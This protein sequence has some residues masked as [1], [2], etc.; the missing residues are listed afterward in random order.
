MQHPKRRVLTDSQPPNKAE[1]IAKTIGER[2]RQLL[3]TTGLLTIR[4]PSM[5]PR[6]Y[7]TLRWGLKP[8]ADFPDDVV[9]YIDGSMLNPRRRELAT[10]GF[11]IAAVGKDDTLWEWASGVPPAW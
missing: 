2:R 11:A 6:K 4:L 1:L 9:W 5:E 10:C 8:T 7:D 3:R